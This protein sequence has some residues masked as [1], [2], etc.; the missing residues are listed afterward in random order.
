MKRANVHEAKTH[1][2]RYLDEVAAGET[3]VICK[4]NRPVAELRPIPAKP[5]SLRAWGTDQGVLVVPKD[6]NAPLS[7]DIL[8][9]WGV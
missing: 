5:T 4:H 2:S 9:D 7:E 8:A 6:I 3:I 1:L